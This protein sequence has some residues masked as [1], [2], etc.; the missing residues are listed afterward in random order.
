LI[1]SRLSFDPQQRISILVWVEAEVVDGAPARE[2]VAEEE[3]TVVVVAAVVVALVLAGLASS[4][5][6]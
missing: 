4:P 2:A 5:M 6:L 3:Q 1:S